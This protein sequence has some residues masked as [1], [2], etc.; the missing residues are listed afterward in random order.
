MRNQKPSWWQLY[1]IA[2]LM[3]GTLLWNALYGDKG[4]WGN[5]EDGGILI[6]GFVLMLLWV[7]ANQH[8]IENEEWIQSEARRASSRRE[9]AR[10]FR[11]QS[12]LV[13]RTALRHAPPRTGF[14]SAR[15]KRFG[16]VARTSDMRDTTQVSHVR[17]EK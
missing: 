17:M 1:A 16:F 11:S 14:G 9:H 12:N 6:G 15:G 10:A 2:S 13:P 5:F 3:F 4:M 8:A 7:K